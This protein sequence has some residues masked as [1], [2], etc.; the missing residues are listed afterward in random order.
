MNCWNIL[1]SRVCMNCFKKPNNKLFQETNFNCHYVLNICIIAQ[2]T[3]KNAMVL[4]LTLLELIQISH[5]HLQKTKQPCTSSKNKT[6]MYIALFI[7]QACTLLYSYC[8]LCSLR[9]LGSKR[10]NIHISASRL[11]TLISSNF[12]VVDCR[13]VCFTK[14]NE[15]V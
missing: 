8:M 14:K 1:S 5:V 10:C 13:Y 7:L 3:I 12:I 11:L 2:L 15:L 9:F 4:L 6:G